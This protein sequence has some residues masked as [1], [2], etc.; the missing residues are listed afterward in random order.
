MCLRV[1]PVRRGL[2]LRAARPA[3][4]LVTFDSAVQRAGSCSKEKL[5]PARRRLVVFPLSLSGRVC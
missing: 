5:L 2:P 1:F 3:A 4:P